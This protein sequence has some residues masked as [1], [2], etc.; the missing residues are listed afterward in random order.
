MTSGVFQPAELRG[1]REAFDE[2]TSRPWFNPDPEARQAFA[3][4]LIEAYPGGTF[5]PHIDL[6]LLEATAKAHYSKKP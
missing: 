3:R 2:I 6:P 1:L 5:D 4:Y